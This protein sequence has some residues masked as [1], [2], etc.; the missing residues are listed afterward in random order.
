MKRISMVWHL[1]SSLGM[2]VVDDGCCVVGDV[3]DPGDAGDAGEVGDPG[4]TGDVGDP[5]DAGEPGEVDDPGDAGD[6]G[7][8]GDAGDVGDPGDAEDPGDAGDVLGPVYGE[9]DPAGVEAFVVLAI[10]VVLCPVGGLGLLTSLKQ[11]LMRLKVIL[12]K[13]KI[14][15]V[16]KVRYKFKKLLSYSDHIK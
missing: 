14:S 3:G 10:T 9:V 15:I 7:D 6:V 11:F 13:Y 2:G 1:L 8:P 16:A 4:D 12:L 5:G